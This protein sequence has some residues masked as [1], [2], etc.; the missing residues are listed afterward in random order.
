MNF[1]LSEYEHVLTQQATLFYHKLV[2][3]IH[4]KFKPLIGQF[5][6][7]WMC[8]VGIVRSLLKWYTVTQCKQV[9]PLP[10]EIWTV[11]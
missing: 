10:L 1:D 2:D 11:I 6:E 5:C 7:V 8:D 4:K 9:R 3:M